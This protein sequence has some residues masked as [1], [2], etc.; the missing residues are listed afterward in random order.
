MASATTQRSLFVVIPGEN[1]WN[2]DDP[3]TSSRFLLAASRQLRARPRSAVQF[4]TNARDLKVMLLDEVAPSDT[5][6]VAMSETQKVELV[7][8]HP[9]LRVAPAVEAR[10]LWLR[11]Q[12][13][14]PVVSVAAGAK[15]AFEVTVVDTVSG[16]PMRDVEVIGIVDRVNRVGAVNRTN[17]RGVA[18]LMFPSSV[19]K[20]ESVEAHP[21]SGHWSTY[22]TGVSLS[23]G[24]HALACA[25]IDLSQGDVRRHFKLEGNDG[26]GEGVKVGVVDTGVARKHPDLR[27]AHGMNVVRGEANGSYDDEVGHGTHVCGIIAGR[28][29]P[30][31]GVR[32]VAPGVELNV[33]RVF[34]KGQESALSFSI[35]KG[36]RQAVD[37]GCDLINL[38]LGGDTDMPDVLREIQRARALGT[39]CVA[40]AGNDYR[41]PVS[42]PARY[43]QVLALSACGRDKTF[44]PGSGQELEVAK[45]HGTDRRDFIAAFSNVGQDIDLTGPG[46]GIVSTFPGGY[47]VMDGTSMACPAATGA[48]ARILAGQRAI[49]TADRNQKRSDAII[50]LALSKPQLLGFG[51][52]FEGAGILI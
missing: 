45:P 47:A 38:S 7:R 42:Y 14:V 34:G 32:G 23:K 13:L 40:A 22:A 11:G 49:L 46:V 15:V 10:L 24:K 12:K 4:S 41:A 21:A 19:K 35:A 3:G 16:Q 52:T 6:L 17:A 26:D 33:Y 43:G 36:I 1:L 8:T 29:K 18:R 39:V 2:Q 30:G 27:V 28:G 5:V 25:P 51:P 31:V 48:L 44:P 9:G 50:K 20:L 37:D